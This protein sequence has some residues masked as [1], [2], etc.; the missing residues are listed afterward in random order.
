MMTKEENG[1]NLIAMKP[2]NIQMYLNSILNKDQSMEYLKDLFAEDTT[3][4]TF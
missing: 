1:I 4:N 2:A 3:A